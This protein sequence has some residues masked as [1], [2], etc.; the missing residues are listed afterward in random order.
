M[1]LG[2]PTAQKGMIKELNE[3]DL[4]QKNFSAIGVLNAASKISRS[5]VTPNGR[6]RE[7]RLQAALRRERRQ[8]GL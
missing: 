2:R 5:P 3:R 1:A 8:E 7:I 4:R 6:C